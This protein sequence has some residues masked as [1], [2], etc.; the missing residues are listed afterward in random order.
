MM[1]TQSIDLILPSSVL[2]W[3]RANLS[4]G[5]SLAGLAG[6]LPVGWAIANNKLIT[7]EGRA[8]NI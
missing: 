5:A 1:T 8:Y 6:R 3:L 2:A 7:P 4:S